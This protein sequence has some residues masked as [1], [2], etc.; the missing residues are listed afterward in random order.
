M[1]IN[2]R[3]MD[4]GHIMSSGKNL[5]T[6]SSYNDQLSQ[7]TNEMQPLKTSSSS[8]WPSIGNQMYHHH[9]HMNHHA[10][11][12]H[13]HHHQVMRLA[14]ATGNQVDQSSAVTG[15]STA[16][17]N[18]PPTT[19]AT[20]ANAANVQS[21]ISPSDSGPSNAS[22]D[23]NDS[24][25][26]V[27]SGT[28]EHKG[29]IASRSEINYPVIG[30]HSSIYLSKQNRKLV[31]F[32]TVIAYIFFVSLA[33]I[34]LSFFYFFLWDPS[35]E[36]GVASD[37]PHDHFT[38]SV[39]LMGTVMERTGRKKFG[40][41]H[42]PAAINPSLQI[43]PDARNIPCPCDPTGHRIS[44]DPTSDSD[45]TSNSNNGDS[46]VVVPPPASPTIGHLQQGIHVGVGSKSLSNAIPTAPS[47]YE[48][49]ARRP[50]VIPIHSS[51]VNDHDHDATSKQFDE[52]QA[53]GPSHIF[54]VEPDL[55][56]MQNASSGAMNSH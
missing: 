38:G 51:F 13:P 33:A 47:V 37:V 8:L 26:T 34:V 3:A 4:E 56:D 7:K 54:T 21:A 20:T 31:R 16:M 2:A 40:A 35:M 44:N 24:N 10:F 11:Q 55:S 25:G 49:I 43:H 36:G 50:R 5:Q 9:H 39:A 23:N 27:F 45:D 53:D 32:V 15:E 52:K 42:F 17:V 48:L 30:D 22:L 12:M 29:S 18:C 41:S 14:S 1:N 28:P 46:N 6:S 19:T